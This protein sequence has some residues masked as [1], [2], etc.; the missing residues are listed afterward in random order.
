[1]LSG[2]AISMESPPKAARPHHP[3]EGAYSPGCPEPG[4]TVH[5]ATDDTSVIAMIPTER[6]TQKPRPGRHDSSASRERGRNTQRP[7]D[8]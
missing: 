5:N 3:P 8:Q 2:E 7:R 1:M 4:A 6:P